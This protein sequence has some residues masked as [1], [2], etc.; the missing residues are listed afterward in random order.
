[1]G[2]VGLGE[3][4]DFRGRKG[5]IQVVDDESDVGQSIGRGRGGGVRENS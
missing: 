4:V 2:A 1:M 5:W 3:R